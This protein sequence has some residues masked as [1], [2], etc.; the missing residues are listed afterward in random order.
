MSLICSTLGIFT[1]KVEIELE[2]I[3]TVFMD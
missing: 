2:G 3:T 1:G